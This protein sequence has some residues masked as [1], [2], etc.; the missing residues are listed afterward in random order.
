MYRIM[1]LLKR[2][3]Y[4]THAQFRAHFE[5]SHSAMAQKYCGHLFSQYQ[6]HYLET[7]MDGGDSRKENSGFGPRPSNWDLLSG[8]IGLARED[9]HIAAGVV[10][11]GTIAAMKTTLSGMHNG[12]ALMSFTSTCFISTDVEH[13]RRQR[14]GIPLPLRLA[15]GHDGRLP[16]TCKSST[17]S[18][19][20]TTPT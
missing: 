10:P 2:K 20:K 14:M 17:P 18:H 1:F 8:A 19:S 5:L 12:K 6:R 3:P 13:Q 11:K 7:V 4:L 16:S 9:V 15:P